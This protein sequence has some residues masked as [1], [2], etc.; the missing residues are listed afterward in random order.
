MDFKPNAATRRS[1]LRRIRHKNK[2]WKIG[3]IY[4]SISIGFTVGVI[5]A[6]IAGLED[7]E[8]EDKTAIA[9][10]IAV[11]VASIIPTLAGISIKRKYDYRG[12][13]PYSSQLNGYLSLYEDELE[14]TFWHVTS[15][16]VNIYSKYR[17]YNDEDMF[18]FSVNA[19]YIRGIAFK[20]N[21]CYIDGDG[22]VVSPKWANDVTTANYDGRSFSFVMAF[23]DDD[24]EKRIREWMNDYGVP[25][26]EMK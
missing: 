6:L 2:L 7:Y 23:D 18:I 4:L 9:I 17:E 1:S 10:A 8:I 3:V 25:E 21:V 11:G 12:A 15:K 19:F 13:L 5:G 20:D 26:F 22:Y 24:M 14:Y 16:D